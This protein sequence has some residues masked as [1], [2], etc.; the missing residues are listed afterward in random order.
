MA[1]TP[2]TRDGR[3]HLSAPPTTVREQLPALKDPQDNQ[4][5]QGSRPRVHRVG[6]QSRNINDDLIVFCERSRK[7]QTRWTSDPTWLCTA[8]ANHHAQTRTGYFHNVRAQVAPAH[9]GEVPSFPQA[10]IT[11]VDD[12]RSHVKGLV[13]GLAILA[14]L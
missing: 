4:A 1:P 10:R 5:I 7:T 8:H 6:W 9:P 12:A 14:M 3:T 2:G 13:D 11:P